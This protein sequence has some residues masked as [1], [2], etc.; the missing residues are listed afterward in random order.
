[1]DKYYEDYWY[2]KSLDDTPHAIWKKSVLSKIDLND[3]NYLDIG[4]G[5]GF[6]SE[7]FLYNHKVYGLDISENALK[8]ANKK[9]LIV[10]K[11]DFSEK[12]LPF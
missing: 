12:T 9:G 5:N 2:N 11:H 8:E 1:M 3:G 4:C 10:N 6:I 7:Q